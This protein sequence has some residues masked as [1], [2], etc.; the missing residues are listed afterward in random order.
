[1]PAAKPDGLGGRARLSEPGEDRVTASYGTRHGKLRLPLEDPS[2]S[3]PETAQ[4]ILAAAGRLL[5]DR[6]YEAVTLENVAAEAG[7]NKASIRYNFGN[8]A[9]LLMAVVDDLIHDECLRLAADTETVPEEERLHVAMLGIRRMIVEADSFRG[10]FD[11][12]PHAFRDPDLRERMF[13][14]YV[15]W[16]QQNL[17]WLGLAGNRSAM[18]S[19]M[20]MGLAELIAAIPDGLS[21]QAG[22]NPEGF[23]LSR[24]LATLE[25]LLR[26]S[27]S[28]LVEL[29]EREAEQAAAP[30]V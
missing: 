14:L 8:K 3:L 19:D 24:P 5:A 16:Y 13:S 23:D 25:F 11:I 28:Q 29:A 18:D 30:G 21:V 22:L 26:N 27:M 17:K 15:W 4:R 1:M 10:F 7:V 9:G 20:L 2:S 12:L 6:G